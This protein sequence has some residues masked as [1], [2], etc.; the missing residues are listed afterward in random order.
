MASSNPQCSPDK[1][2]P[3]ENYRPAMHIRLSKTLHFEAAHFLPCFPEGHKCRRMHGH[4]FR[5]EIF[6][7][8]TVDP[9][10]GY[11]IDYGDLKRATQPLIDR[12]DHYVLNDIPGLQNP[13]AEVLAH[14][15]YHQLKPALPLLSQVT[16][17]E[18]CTSRCDYFGG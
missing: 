17:Y 18:T 8:G 15:I 6:V 2:R 12:L 13:T 10:R 11:L 5:V 14:Y 4:S 1:N 9:A 16:I 3:A 7:E